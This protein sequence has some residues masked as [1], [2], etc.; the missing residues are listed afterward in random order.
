MRRLPVAYP[1]GETHTIDEGW[2]RFY[3]LLGR[4]AFSGLT[5]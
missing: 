4:L 1:D 3:S 5:A 2:N